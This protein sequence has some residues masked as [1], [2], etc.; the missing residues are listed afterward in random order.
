MMRAVTIAALLLSAAEAADECGATA[1]P[2]TGFNTTDYLGEWYQIAV[3]T[4][5]FDEHERSHPLCIRAYYSTNPAGYL[6]VVNMGFNYKGEN[7]SVQGKA[8]QADPAVGALMVSFFNSRPGPYNIIKLVSSE[9]H[10]TTALVWTCDTD[11]IVRDLWIL[12]KDMHVS[13][14]VISDLYAF[15]DSSN[16]DVE[17]LRM[18]RTVQNCTTA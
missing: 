17:K 9:G 3:S 8:T 16:I 15:A 13:E 4:A 11:G 18:L 10:Y 7:S 12:S 1:A 6:N 5:F 2:V 14:E